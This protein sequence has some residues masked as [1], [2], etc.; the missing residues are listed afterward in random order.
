MGYESCLGKVAAIFE[1]KSMFTVHFLPP[2]QCCSSLSRAREQPR[3]GARTLRFA[4]TQQVRVARFGVGLAPLFL[5][6]QRE[7]L[8]RYP[9]R[10]PIFDCSANRWC[11][12]VQR[13]A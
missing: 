9:P 3:D 13:N 6:D 1:G 12:K 11:G 4:G 5:L 7:S 2:L 10:L 8:T